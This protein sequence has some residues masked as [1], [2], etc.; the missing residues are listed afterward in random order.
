[1][2]IKPLWAIIFIFKI[3]KLYGI[4]S[5][6]PSTCKLLPIIIVIFCYFSKFGGNYLEFL[7][8]SDVFNLF[9]SSWLK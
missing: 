5:K 6:V 4:T 3:K 8:A 7:N 1:M 9:V 2:S